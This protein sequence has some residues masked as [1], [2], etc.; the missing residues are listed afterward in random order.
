MSSECLFS[1]VDTFSVDWLI[2]YLTNHYSTTDHHDTLLPTAFKL[3][4][5]LAIIF[6]YD[7]SVDLFSRLIENMWENWKMF[8][9][10]CFPQ[11]TVQI[12]QIFSLLSHKNKEKL[13]IRFEL[14]SLA[15]V[16][17]EHFSFVST[18]TLT[19]R[20]NHPNSA[21]NRLFF[22]LSQFPGFS[23]YTCLIQKQNEP[24]WLYLIITVAKA[25]Q[26][27]HQLQYSCLKSNKTWW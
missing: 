10:A 5:Q 3:G 27:G 11:R 19:W 26:T 21:V 12:P 16:K 1:L 15:P 24:V 6:I 8:Q 7:E 20:K 13:M 14:C 18:F 9:V 22:H 25:A 2:D 4:L 23:V 17:K